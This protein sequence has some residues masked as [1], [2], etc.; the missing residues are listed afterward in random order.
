MSTSA[1]S[2]SDE[3]LFEAMAHAEHRETAFRELY[4]RYEQRT[5]AYSMV[6]V[7]VESRAKDLVQETFYRVFQSACKGTQVTN[8]GAY[9][10]R[11]LRNLCIDDIRKYSRDFVDV[12]EVEIAGQS[13]DY[14]QIEMQRV[15][16]AAMQLLPPEHRDALL[17]QAYGGMTY[18]QI[19][20]DQGVPVSTIRN[21]IVRAKARLRKILQPYLYSG[22]SR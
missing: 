3:A 7:H 13:R 19:A 17:L 18:E 10:M 6:C 21:R 5:W 16:E 9:I 8:V 20:Q 1:P 22:E 2:Y 11:I 15:L 12:D 4:R 14:E